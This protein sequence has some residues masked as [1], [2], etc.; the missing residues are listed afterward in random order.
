VNELIPPKTTRVRTTGSTPILEAAIGS[1]RM[2]A[3]AH[4]EAIVKKALNAEPPPCPSSP[5]LFSP[6]SS[7]SFSSTVLI[8]KSGV[9]S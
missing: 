6:G 9:G 4:A 5:P 2:P 3:P 8:A 1:E 7:G